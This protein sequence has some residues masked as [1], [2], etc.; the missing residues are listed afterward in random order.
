MD[1]RAPG[2]QDPTEPIGVP[3]R[4]P[5]PSTAATTPLSE[6]E[7]KTLPLPVIPTPA[8]AAAPARTPRRRRTGLVAALAVLVV[9][10]VAAAAGWFVGNAWSKNVVIDQ[11]T[12]HTRAALGLDDTAEVDV[13]VDDPMLPQLVTGVLSRLEVTVPDAPI[14]GATGEVGLQATGIPIRGDGAAASAAARVRLAP[15]ALAK[16]AGDIGRTV[17][18]SLRIVGKNVAVKLDPAQFLSGV[19]FTL[20]LR[21]SAA[22]GALVLKPIAFD[23][24][25]AQVSADVIRARFGTLADGILADR[26]VCVA[27]RFPQGMRL[28]SIAVDPDAVV[29]GFAVDPRILTDASLQKP[30][31]CR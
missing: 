28:T 17:P 27:D 8:P 14:G 31:S 30:G 29:A 16:L 9:L 19:S 11:V 1:D 24:G 22:D 7:A 10:A 6:P 5:L 3:P 25:G 15:A 21:P 18:G 4:P 2:A 12:Q 23:V 13:H 20:T 26:T